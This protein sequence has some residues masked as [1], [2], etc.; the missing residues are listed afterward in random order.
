[1]KNEVGT[2]TFALLTMLACWSV[3]ARADGFECFSAS[4]DLKIKI[5]NF[6]HASDGTRNFDFMTIENPSEDK[7]LLRFD[8][9]TGILRNRATYYIAKVDLRFSQLRQSRLQIF[10]QS[11]VDF[12]SI[13][14][15]IDFSYNNPVSAGTRV[16]AQL[17][18]INRETRELIK[19]A[20]TCERTTGTP[21]PL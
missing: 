12:D 11:V 10:N 20:L 16:R 1:M 19:Q 3:D 14:L 9:E 8:S 5:E 6:R 7:S 18:A 13:Y 15:D 2:L 4:S 17:S 21:V